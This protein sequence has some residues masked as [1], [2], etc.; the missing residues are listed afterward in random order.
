MVLSASSLVVDAGQGGDVS[1]LYSKETYE[2]TKSKGGWDWIAIRGYCSFGGLDPNGKAGLENARAAGIAEV[3]VYLFPC[4]NKAASEQVDATV[5]AYHG[6]Y[7]KIW[8]DIETNPS[9]GCAWSGDL[10]SNCDYMGQLISA[11]HARGATTGIY[12]SAY[13]WSII[14]GDGCHVGKDNGVPLWYADYDYKP[15]FDG[16]SGFG[17]WTSPYGKQYWDSVDFGCAINADADWKP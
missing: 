6:L 2:C 8:F 1:E 7:D 16:F 3:D 13:M 12:A 10:A 4:R 5:D 14:M 17:G 15:N 11:A 9:P